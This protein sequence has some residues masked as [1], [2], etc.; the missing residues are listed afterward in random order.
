MHLTGLDAEPK[1]WILNAK[2]FIEQLF[3]NGSVSH[4]INY[5]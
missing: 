3:V 2:K 1:P 5:Y 4:I